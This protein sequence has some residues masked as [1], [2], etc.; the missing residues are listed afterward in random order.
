MIFIAILG[1]GLVAVLVKDAIL[2]KKDASDSY[3]K[4]QQHPAAYQ[5]LLGTEQP[6][7]SGLYQ[8]V[9]ANPQQKVVTYC[10]ID[11][12]LIDDQ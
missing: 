12:R 3:E 11:G 10:M 6:L 9:A 2:K 8:P 1:M 4:L 5:G 7:G